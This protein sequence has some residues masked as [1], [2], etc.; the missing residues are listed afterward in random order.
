MK[1]PK[2][3]LKEIDSTGLRTEAHMIIQRAQNE[4]YNEAIQDALKC[5]VP[6]TSNEMDLDHYEKIKEQIKQLTKK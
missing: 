5:I 4:A 3:L 6:L 1:T 2:E